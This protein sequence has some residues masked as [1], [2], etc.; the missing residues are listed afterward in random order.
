LR[1]Q[2]SAL[3]NVATR[4]DRARI[5]VDPAGVGLL[6]LGGFDYVGRSAQRPGQDRRVHDTPPTPK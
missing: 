2:S 4:P 3:R 1:Q 6:A 5:L